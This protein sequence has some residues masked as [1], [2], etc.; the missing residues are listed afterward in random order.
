VID[1]F[2]SLADLSNLVEMLVLPRHGTNYLIDTVSR[3][4]TNID[5]MENDFYR[6]FS[7]EDRLEFINEAIK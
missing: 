4:A 5:L 3:K 1:E 6:I 2:D 7:K